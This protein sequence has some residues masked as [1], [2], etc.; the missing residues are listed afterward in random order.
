MR[1]LYVPSVWNMAPSYRSFRMYPVVHLVHFGSF[2]GTGLW[3]CNCGIVVGLVF[4]RPIPRSESRA[5]LEHRCPFRN[6]GWHFGV[7]PISTMCPP[8]AWDVAVPRVLPCYVCTFAPLPPPPSDGD[9]AFVWNVMFRGHNF[10]LVVTG[11]GSFC[12]RRLYP[13]NRV[14]F[15]SVLAF[16]VRGSEERR[17]LS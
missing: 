5:V 6:S 8:V 3:N 11:A 14:S 4:V 12:V 2:C 13:S 1:R 9:V 7:Q 16:L 10:A 15:F 17:S